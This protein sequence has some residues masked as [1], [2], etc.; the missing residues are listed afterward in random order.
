M[1]RSTSRREAL[2]EHLVGLVE[3]ED[4]DGVEVQ[5]AAL[6]VVEDAAG[7]ANDD[8]GAALEGVDLRAVAD[9]AVDGQRREAGGLAELRRGRRRP[10]APALA[11]A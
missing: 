5:G 4:A 2:V 10:A 11:W 1:M 6:Q 7:R 9:A 8:L 3:D